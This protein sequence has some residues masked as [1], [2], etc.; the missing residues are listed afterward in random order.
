MRKLKD[1]K[2]RAWHEES[3]M[4]LIIT[5]FETW[6]SNGEFMSDGYSFDG[7]FFDGDYIGHKDIILMQYSD[8]K[9]KNGKEICEGDIL[10]FVTFDYNG[11][12]HEYKG[13]VKCSHGMFQIWENDHN[14]FYGVDEAFLLHWVVDQDEEIEIIGNIYDNPEL[15]LNRE[16]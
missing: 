7:M 15:L 4:W 6:G 5:G 13:V 14:E 9:D 8:L 2:F 10:S 12:N 16:E 1:F 3:E 11:F